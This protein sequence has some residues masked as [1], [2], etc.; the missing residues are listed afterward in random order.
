MI[1]TQQLD[2]TAA[3]AATHAKYDFGPLELDTEARLL[4]RDGELVD[5]APRVYA[6]LEYLVARAGNAVSRDELL[7]S[8]WR[9]VAV[10]EHS[11][12]EAIWQ[13]R[14]AL[15]DDSRQP[16]YVQT[17]PK[18]GFRFIAPVSVENPAGDKIRYAPASVWRTM[19]PGIAAGLVI[20]AM[21]LA[22]IIRAS[23]APGDRTLIRELATASGDSIPDS[24]AAVSALA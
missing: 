14:K 21:L 12:S 13:L 22:T 24:E 4:K 17:V 10:S 23:L 9:Q 6:L 19:V 3:N 11:L 1:P 16:V 20:T 7:D 15:G 8:I 18:Y 2:S 5:L